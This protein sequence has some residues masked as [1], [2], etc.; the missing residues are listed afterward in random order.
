MQTWRE[1]DTA[2]SQDPW[3]VLTLDCMFVGD[4]GRSDLAGDE[5]IEEQT[6]NLYQSLAP[7]WV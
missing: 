6:L 2:R 4:I 5:L 3:M 1:T 7:N